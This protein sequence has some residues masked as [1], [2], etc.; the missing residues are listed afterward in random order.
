MKTEKISKIINV[1]EYLPNELKA[2]KEIDNIPKININMKNIIIIVL[3]V[4]FVYVIL[5]VPYGFNSSLWNETIK[6]L[7]ITLS[8]I[9]PL[10]SVWAIGF[11]ESINK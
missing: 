7:F 5:A 4:L 3:S 11:L 8:F 1:S 6:N 2:F 9:V 10:F